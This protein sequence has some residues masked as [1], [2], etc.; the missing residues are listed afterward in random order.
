MKKQKLG[1]QG[2]EISVVGFGAWEAGGGIW[3]EVPDDQTIEAMRAAAGLGQ[4]RDVFHVQRGQLV[5][6]ALVG[7]PGLGEGHVRV[8][9]GVERQ[10]LLGG[11]GHAGTGVQNHAQQAK[12]LGAIDTAR[13]VWGTA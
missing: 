7:L 11:S 3:G 8:L 1:S 5:E 12:R 4:R 9:L 6:V 2:P 10:C 13:E